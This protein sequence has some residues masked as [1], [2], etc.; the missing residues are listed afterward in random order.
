MNKYINNLTVL[1]VDDEKSIVDA[2]AGSLSGY[3]RKVALNA[4]Q[5]LRIIESKDPPDIIL[6]DV[7]MPGIDGF[8]LCRRIKSGKNKH[9]PIILVSAKTSRKDVEMG[10]SLG[11]HYYIHKPFTTKEVQAVV[12]SLAAGMISSR[13]LK[14]ARMDYQRSLLQL[15]IKGS[16]RFRTYAD[17]T[18]L[19]STLSCLSEE[20]LSTYNGLREL[21]MNAVEHGNLGF[22]YEEKKKFL[23][24]GTFHDEV[25]SRLKKLENVK[26]YA[27]LDYEVS[28]SQVH[29]VIHDTGR[30]FHWKN[31]LDFSMDRAFDPNG[32]GIAIAKKTC[33]E[34]LDFQGCGNKVKA[35]ARK[36]TSLPDFEMDNT[37]LLG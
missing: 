15:S 16:Y 30:G 25:E 11:A 20:K 14:R 31:Y 35:I 23:N 33:F 12:G 17:V 21:M 1:I 34:E 9:I 27:Y 7:N 13:F 6:S 36:A 22:T 3:S 10:Y 29:F 32:R 19:A 28:G 18:S 2:L 8:E 24:D 26:K 5:A 4:E 37:E